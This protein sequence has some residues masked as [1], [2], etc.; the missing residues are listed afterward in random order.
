MMQW[1]EGRITEISEPLLTAHDRGLTLGDGL[2]ETLPSFHGHAF[3]LDDHRDRMARSAMRLD[4]PFDL[5][6]FDTA[7]T[8]LSA[9]NPDPATIRVT[10]TRGVGER[11]LA[12]PEPQKPVLFATRTAWSNTLAFSTMRL[13]TSTIR[14]NPTSPTA[15]LKTLSYLDN[16]MAHQEARISGADDALMLDLDGHVASTSMA[17]I[18]ALFGQTLYTPSDQGAILPGIMRQLICN[19]VDEFGLTLVTKPLHRRD[20]LAADHVFT[21]NSVRLLTSITHLDGVQLRY[22]A[23]TIVKRITDFIRSHILERC[24]VRI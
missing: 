3:L 12:F 21:T 1:R 20:L 7:V 10:L 16:V 17:N 6:T 4:M 15:S 5:R 18:F 24:G 8:A 2:F 11:G 9:R 19:H 14:R 22:Q 23:Q 13:T